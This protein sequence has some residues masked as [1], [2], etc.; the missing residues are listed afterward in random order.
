MRWCALVR[1]QE[2]RRV[3]TWIC[4][5]LGGQK[6]AVVARILRYRDGAGVYRVVERLEAR[7]KRDRVL[8][9]QLQ[10]TQAE[11]CHPRSPGLPS[12]CNVVKYF[13]TLSHGTVSCDLVKLKNVDASDMRRN[14]SIGS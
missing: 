5:W 6:M 10:E 1:H 8:A 9:A 12:H 14:L 11:D 13:V 3:G 2:D 4:V 7:A